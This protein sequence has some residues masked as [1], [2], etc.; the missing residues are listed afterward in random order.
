LIREA[1]SKNGKVRLANGRV[2]E[3]G[4][5]KHLLELDR[6]INE[7]DWFRRN[8]IGNNKEYRKERYTI[9]RAVDSLRNMRRKAKRH[10]IKNQLL[11]ERDL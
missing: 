10:G 8:I 7:L 2:V 3:K 5:K 11:G 9:S 6:L 1:I 4:S